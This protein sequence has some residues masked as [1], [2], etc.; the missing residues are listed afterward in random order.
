[1]TLSRAAIVGSIV[2]RLGYG[3]TGKFSKYS[4]GAMV[5]RMDVVSRL[6]RF[7][8]G[9]YEDREAS[10]VVW[11]SEGI[12]SPGWLKVGTG[13]RS[14]TAA[15]VLSCPV[16]FEMMGGVT[17]NRLASRRKRHPLASSTEGGAWCQRTTCWHLEIWPESLD[18]ARLKG[19]CRGEACTAAKGHWVCEPAHG[20]I[21]L[22]PS[23]REASPAQRSA[24]LFSSAM[25]F[26]I[27]P[28]FDH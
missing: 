14:M 12:R 6:A 18:Y 27:A 13:I 1:L 2:R 25:S 9:M 26:C 10:V 22:F 17:S 21:P 24:R 3:T 15:V 8:A 20:L 5:S 19:M 28:S 11:L 7:V 23:P 4:L 16:G